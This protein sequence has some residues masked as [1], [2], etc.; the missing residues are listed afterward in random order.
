MYK[1]YNFITSLSTLIISLFI[2][3]H[4]GY[5]VYHM[6]IFIHTALMANDVEYVFIFLITIYIYLLWRNTYS[7][8]L[9][10]KNW[11]VY[12]CWISRICYIFWIITKPLYD[13]Q[14][15]P[16]VMFFILFANMCFLIGIFNM[17]I[18]NLITD[19]LAFMSATL[20]ICFIYV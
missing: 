10:F 6:V 19:N 2:Y 7:N 3:H 4:S 8:L 12:F 20:L 16:P 18:F 9:P 13:L 15:L 5:E 11:I 1:S 14:I 17:C